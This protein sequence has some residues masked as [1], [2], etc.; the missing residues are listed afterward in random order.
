MVKS[1][2]GSGERPGAL[3][4]AGFSER[5]LTTCAAIGSCS[6]NCRPM[7]PTETGMP[8][9]VRNLL[10]VIP[11]AQT[12]CFFCGW[13]SIAAQPRDVARTALKLPDGSHWIATCAAAVLPPL[14]SSTANA[15]YR[16]A[17]GLFRRKAWRFSVFLL[18]LCFDD[19]SLI[20]VSCSE[21]F[22]TILYLGLSLALRAALDHPS[23]LSNPLPA[24]VPGELLAYV[25]RVEMLSST[26]HYGRNKDAVGRLYVDTL[27]LLSYCVTSPPKMTKLTMHDSSRAG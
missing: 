22:S 1:S 2:S 12:D 8:S 4:T 17:A 5:P 14:L 9:R 23:S 18:C 19:L 25:R 15:R 3:S 11:R 26:R 6:C 13:C 20:G 24:S 16:V 7:I 27:L 21:L 10:N